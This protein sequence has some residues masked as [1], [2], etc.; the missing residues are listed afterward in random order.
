MCSVPITSTLSN[1]AILCVNPTFVAC[2]FK[3]ILKFQC[4]F[5]IFKIDFAKLMIV[6]QKN[7]F[8][9][10]KTVFPSCSSKT[11]HKIDKFC[12]QKNHWPVLFRISIFTLDSTTIDIIWTGHTI[13]LIPCQIPNLPE[14]ILQIWWFGNFDHNYIWKAI[15]RNINEYLLF[16]IVHCDTFVTFLQFFLEVITYAIPNNNFA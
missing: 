2:V 14:M 9:T 10:L 7:K 3:L 12:H 15:C 6:C 8:Y 11:F 4:L 16:M 1:K 13:V 5:I